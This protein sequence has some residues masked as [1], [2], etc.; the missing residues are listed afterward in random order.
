MYSRTMLARGLKSQKAL[1]DRL[2]KLLVA[3]TVDLEECRELVDRYGG[4]GA[5]CTVGWVI[6]RYRVG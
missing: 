3:Q 2:E 5:Q 1:T 4:R 6:V